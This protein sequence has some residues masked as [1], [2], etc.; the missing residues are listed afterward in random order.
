ML[1]SMD[2]SLLFR[3]L[4]RKGG[5]LKGG[6]MFGILLLINSFVLKKESLAWL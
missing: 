3:E 5:N 4:S 2:Y 6:K 1:D